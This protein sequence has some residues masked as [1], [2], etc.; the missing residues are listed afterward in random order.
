MYSPFLYDAVYMYALALN[1]TLSYGDSMQDGIAV[2]N[3]TKN[4]QFHG[5]VQ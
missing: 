3:H 4:I 2:T 1:K 5:N